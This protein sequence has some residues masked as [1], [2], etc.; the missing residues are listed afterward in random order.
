MI[1]P[2]PFFDLRPTRPT[3]MPGGT[4]C[5][6]CSRPPERCLRGARGSKFP[7][8]PRRKAAPPCRRMRAQGTPIGGSQK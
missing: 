5:V 7:E 8:G 3:D 6:V 2:F 1:F 4:P